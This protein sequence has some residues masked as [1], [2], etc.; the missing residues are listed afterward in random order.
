MSTDEEVSEVVNWIQGVNDEVERNSNHSPK[1]GQLWYIVSLSWLAK[2]RESP[3]P[4]PLNNR[5]LVDNNSECLKLKEEV[6]LKRGL[7]EKLD[8]EIV[9]PKAW[10]YFSKRFG[11]LDN[12]VIPRKS[13][14]LNSCE[15][16]VEVNLK[17]LQIVFC[18]PKK[19]IDQEKPYVMFISHNSSLKKTSFKLRKIYQQRYS[20]EIY[21][22]HLRFWKLNP[23]KD[24]QG[25]KK[26]TCK[27]VVFPGVL[28]DESDTLEESEVAD[29]DIIVAEIR[30]DTS[31]WT[32]KERHEEPK[33]AYCKKALLSFKRCAC[34]RFVY[35]DS[36]CMKRD[37][38]WH[39]CTGFSCE[40][41]SEKIESFEKCAC[42]KYLYCNFECIE[43]NKR[44]HDCNKPID[45][46][47]G[48]MGLCGLQNL[49]NTCYMNS[50]LQCLS[51]TLELTEYFLSEEYSNHINPQNPLGTQGVLVTAYAHL[52]KQLWHGSSEFI[53]PWKFKKALGTYARQF[54]GYQQHDC[55]EAISFLLD[56]IHEDLNKVKKKP[57]IEEINT[58]GMDEPE[59]AQKFWDVHL[60]RNQSVVVDLMYGQYRSEVTCPNCSSLSLAFD[61][62]MMLTLPVPDKETTDL[63]VV[64]VPADQTLEVLNL[65]LLL[66]KHFTLQNV[67]KGVAELMKLKSESLAIASVFNYAFES[68]VSKIEQRAST[69]VYEVPET[70]QEEGVFIL[71][72]SLA[73]R[74]YSITQKVGIAHPRI[75][76]VS[77]N[78]TLEQVHFE[79][80]KYITGILGAETDSQRDFASNFSS[81][82]GTG[83]QMLYWLNLVNSNKRRG[84]LGCIYCKKPTCTN[85]PLPY[86]EEPL[87][88]Y[89]KLS[90]ETGHFFKLEVMWPDTFKKEELSVLHSR[91]NHS[92]VSEATKFLTQKKNS[93]TTLDECF[94]FFAS[95]EQLDAQNTTFC[96]K[97]KHHVEGTKKM[98]IYKLPK[99][100]IIHLKRFKQSGYLSSRNNKVVDFPIEG[101][102]MGP[103]AIADKG[104]YDLYAVSN[105]IG[106]LSFGHYTNYAKNSG[107]WYLYDDSRV[108]PVRDLNSIVS[109]SA[110]VLFYKKRE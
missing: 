82:F 63:E 109:Q 30:D 16:Q 94:K 91:R 4:G 64:F 70:S 7:Q 77:K 9:P 10:S 59:M 71:E 57:Y 66:P 100:L 84:Q 51:N 27:G 98:D 83:D 58:E 31:S 86:T 5:P 79:V 21:Q 53:S 40:Y 87:Q 72:Q 15:T 35:C 88:K 49:G 43:R 61:P 18:T 110:Y 67:K 107:K 11:V 37:S 81:L 6:V 28:L 39:Q 13:L 12:L 41:C 76:K 42:G 56:F 80:F 34:K 93:N 45:P 60:S 104:I 19:L 75:V 1:A 102:D 105:H 25:L 8:Y 54:S 32:F 96:P 97:C 106:S 24:F 44:F 38:D 3:D 68:F 33:C 17:P 99:V 65:K 52:V 29:S 85:C 2:W 74:L 36:T 95:P 73:K 47:K 89:I 90:E 92:S 46:F 48:K 101:L 26:A 103:Y 23:E 14:Q 62:F 50:G 22:K 78:A 55:Q 20:K 69:Y 108:T